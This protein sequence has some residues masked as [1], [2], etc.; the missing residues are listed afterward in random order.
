MQK[1]FSLVEFVSETIDLVI[2]LHGRG[3]TSA[4]DRSLIDW[5]KDRMIDCLIVKKIDALIDWFIYLFIS[6]LI[7]YRKRRIIRCA[8]KIRSTPPLQPKPLG[9]FSPFLGW[10]YIRWIELAPLWQFLNFHLRPK[11][12]AIFWFSKKC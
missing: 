4:L 5:W 10:K 9:L 11:I 2:L 1:I 8:A 6:R 12:L 3:K 7:D